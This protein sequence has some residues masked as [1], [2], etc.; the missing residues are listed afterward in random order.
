VFRLDRSTFSPKEKGWNGTARNRAKLTR[1]SSWIVPPSQN[2]KALHR[3]TFRGNRSS[4]R[5]ERS[6]ERLCG[7][8]AIQP[9]HYLERQNGAFGLGPSGSHR[10]AFFV[11]VFDRSARISSGSVVVEHEKAD[12]RA[13]V[14]VLVFAIRVDA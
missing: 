11:W 6:M 3:L 4:F 1:F 5:V 12:C 10:V 9:F 14:W 13:K 7:T 2:D 8:M